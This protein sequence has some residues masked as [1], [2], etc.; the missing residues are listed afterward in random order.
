MLGPDGPDEYPS[1]NGWTPPARRSEIDDFAVDDALAV[2][3][4]DDASLVRQVAVAIRAGR[5]RGG[6]LPH[7]GHRAGSG[8]GK[9]EFPPGWDE[10][11]IISWVRGVSD[12]PSNGRPARGGFELTG[13]YR[14]VTGRLVVSTDGHAWWISTAH[15]LPVS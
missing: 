7:G 11:D 6:S 3:D 2:L 10:Q 1:F 9:T 12:D 15:P 13:T 5:Y 4:G 14:G 8:W